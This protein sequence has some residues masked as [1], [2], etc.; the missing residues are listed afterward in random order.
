[1]IGH[2]LDRFPDDFQVAYNG[3]ARLAVADK[4]L[5]VVASREVL[6]GLN[7]I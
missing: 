2:L 6:Y 4:Q 5:I 1:M 3:I 7:G